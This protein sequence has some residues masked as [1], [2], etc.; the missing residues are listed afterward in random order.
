M[1]NVSLV[2]LLEELIMLKGSDLHIK[3]GSPPCFR[4]HGE[5]LPKRTKELTPEEV[6]KLLLPVL[7]SEQK[8][9]FLTKRDIDFAI[10][11]PGV[12]RFRASLFFQRNSI[13]GVFRAIPFRIRSFDE[14]N[15][16]KVCSSLAM[17]NP[18]LFL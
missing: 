17:K 7:T 9:E 6:E 4:I 8:K 13:T 3:A 14:L 11:V 16:P 1:K 10:N 12:S 5:L 15:L 2:T 18:G